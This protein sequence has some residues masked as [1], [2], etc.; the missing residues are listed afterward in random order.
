MFIF[1][2]VTELEAKILSKLDF[3]WYFEYIILILKEHMI[4]DVILQRL[5]SL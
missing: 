5:R 3:A 4:K 2:F 1:I